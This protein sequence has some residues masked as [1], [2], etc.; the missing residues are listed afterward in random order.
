MKMFEKE[1]VFRWKFSLRKNFDESSKKFLSNFEYVWN[2][3]DETSIE[4][5]L[6]LRQ[7][8]LLIEFIIYFFEGKVASFN[9]CTMHKE[10]DG[11]SYH[12]HGGKNLEHFWGKK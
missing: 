7:E 10:Q 8:S 2:P 12:L 5:C 11:K 6:G 1:E 4:T 9:V 3:N